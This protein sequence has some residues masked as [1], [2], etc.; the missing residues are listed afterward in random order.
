MTAKIRL[1][2]IVPL[3]LLALG[4][5]AA[6]VSGCGATSSASSDTSS[7][8][9]RHAAAE[10]IIAQATGVNPQARSGRIDGWIRGEVK[11]VPLFTGPIEA[12]AN[13]VYNLPEGASVPDLDIDVSLAMNDGLIGGGIVVADGKGYITLGDT[14]Y[15]LPD[16]I[17][18]A[19][20]APARKARNGLTKTG[21]M[22]YVNPQD[23]QR[24][25][26]VI[27]EESVAGVSTQRITADVLVDRVAADMARLVRFLTLIGVPQALGL[28]TELTPKMQAAFVRSVTDLKGEVWTGT[29]DHVLRKAHVTGAMVV[30][31][32]DRKLLLGA[33]SGKLEAMLNIS[34]VG[35]PQTISAPTQ[36][37]S[38][39]DLQAA[40]RALA[41]VVDARG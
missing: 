37:G 27:G 28:P 7:F 4:G 36:L 11:G 12:T 35:K 33:T 2:A 38:Y 1:T 10:K 32:R 19:L 15:K 8:A 41:E 5:L 40:L 18:R 14:G 13:G 17:S 20:V 6:A 34:E 29:D 22:F 16:A 31:K 3:A 30:A 9:A 23:W 21:A 24:N 39:A 26:E 25:A